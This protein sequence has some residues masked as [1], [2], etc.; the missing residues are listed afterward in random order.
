MKKPEGSHMSQ[1]GQWVGDCCRVWRGSVCVC[2]CVC[3]CHMANAASRL[4]PRCKHGEMGDGCCGLQEGAKVVAM[5]WHKY[6]HHMIAIRI[7]MCC[8]VP[9]LCFSFVP[10]LQTRGIEKRDYKKVNCLL[11]CTLKAMWSC[12]QPGSGSHRHTPQ[13]TLLKS[14]SSPICLACEGDGTE[15]IRF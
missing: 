11:L 15:R 12:W 10:S 4:L 8:S 5:A 9:D 13:S 1:A 3:G 2:I 14:L 6:H 7:C